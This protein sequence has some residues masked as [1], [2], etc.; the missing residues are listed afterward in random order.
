MTHDDHELMRCCREGDDDAFAIL[1]HRWEDR[2]RRMLRPLV[3]ARA[4]VDDLAQEVFLRVLG[5]RDRYRPVGAFS[6]WLYRIALNVARDAARRRRTSEPLGNHQPVDGRAPPSAEL[7]HDDLI[8]RIERAIA[9][10]PTPL[11]DAVVM[12]HYGELTFAQ[13]AAVTGVPASTVK[14][15]LHAALIALRGR[16]KAL[17]IDSRELET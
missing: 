1:V 13:I 3:P 10:L 14:S 11:R 5:A 12:K 4:D 17:G 8:G 7:E 2:V 6:T 15:R 9:A 16:L